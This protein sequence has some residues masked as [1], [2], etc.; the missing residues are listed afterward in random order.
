VYRWFS[1]LAVTLFGSMVAMGLAACSATPG[2]AVLTPI[3]IQLRWTHQAQFAGFYAADQNGYYAD[4]KLAVT[5]L[6]GG[7]TGDFIAPV[8]AGTAQFGITNPDSL[9]MAR[10]QGTPVRAI[11]SIMRRN[12]T[13]YMALTSSGIAQP[14]DFIGK[15]VQIGTAGLLRLKMLMNRVGVRPDQYTV[16]DMTPDLT[17]LYSGQ[18]DVRAVNLTNEVIAAKTAG[19]PINIIYPD[20]YGIHSYGDILFTTDTI[21]TANPAVVTRFLRAT[22]KGW[23][24]VVENPETAAKLVSKY[25]P[26]ADPDL[27][28]AEMLAS[29]PLVNTGEDHLGWMKPEMW[30]G[31]ERTLR[32]QQVLTQSVDV[33]QVYTQQFLQEIYGN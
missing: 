32:E 15:K 21:M 4:E 18:V 2:P 22:L 19:Y 1:W 14:K 11:A 31:M 7:P 26:K 6:E 17:P 9:L 10:A 13:V 5:F 33:T 8:L 23:T 25:N 12:P 30:A 28:T 3:T 16:V 24:Y 27:E 29:L 20:D